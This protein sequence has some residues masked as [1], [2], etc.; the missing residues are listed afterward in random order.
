[1][2]AALWSKWAESET[3]GAHGLSFCTV[4][5]AQKVI[6]CLHNILSILVS[7]NLAEKLSGCYSWITQICKDLEWKIRIGSTMMQ[8]GI[9][10]T[11]NNFG[12]FYA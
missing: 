9:T 7:L 12:C 1:M 11:V 8:L 2:S 3:S 10:A 5:L 4:L 6:G